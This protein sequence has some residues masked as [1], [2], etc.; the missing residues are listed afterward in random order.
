MARFRGRA[1]PVGCFRVPVGRLRRDHAERSPS[2]GCPPCRA[3]PRG[4]ACRPCRRCRLPVVLPALLCRT[5]CCRAD[6]AAVPRGTLACPRHRPSAPR[7]APCPARP[8]PC[9]ARPAHLAR[10]PGARCRRVCRLLDFRL[11]C[12]ASRWL[13]HLAVRCV[14]RRRARPFPPCRPFLAH[15]STRAIRPRPALPLCPAARPRPAARSTPAARPPPAPRLSPAHRSFPG[16]A[17]A[18]RGECMGGG[19]GRLMAYLG[20]GIPDWCRR[21]RSIRSVGFR[22]SG[23]LGRPGRCGRVIPS[24]RCR[25]CRGRGTRSPSRPVGPWRRPM[26]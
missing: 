18:A 25:V 4:R 22:R 11:F 15:Q 6:W 19:R 10:R 21:R 12:P 16:A 13:R 17:R 14:P 3:C 7:L 5:L 26:A 20:G 23:R 9:P 24:S 1:C 2:P 8:A